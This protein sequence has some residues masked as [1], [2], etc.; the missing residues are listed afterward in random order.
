MAYFIKSDIDTI[1]MGG[2]CMADKIKNN[3]KK[4]FKGGAIAIFV[5]ILSMAL[6]K[7]TDTIAETIV[8]ADQNVG[9]RS[10]DNAFDGEMYNSENPYKILEIVPDASMAELGYQIGGSSLPVSFEDVAKIY[11]DGLENNKG[12]VL[13]KWRSAYANC[14]DKI[15]DILFIDQ[16]GE[17]IPGYD[18]TWK[19]FTVTDYAIKLTDGTIVTGKDRNIFAAGL[20][21][22]DNIMS[23]AMSVRVVECKD[24]TVELL[25]EYN[26][27]LIYIHLK[28]HAGMTFSNLYT[29]MADMAKTYPDKIDSARYP[30]SDSNSKS[31]DISADS[32]LEIYL[33][34]VTTDYSHGLSSLIIDK[35]FLGSNE[36]KNLSKICYLNYSIIPE[37]F[38]QEFASDYNE[39]KWDSNK[40]IILK[41]DKGTISVNGTN[42]EWTLEYNYK[43]STICGGYYDSSGNLNY[44]K[45]TSAYADVSGTITQWSQ[46]MFYSSALNSS[47]KHTHY[48]YWPYSISGSAVNA[49]QVAEYPYIPAG[50]G[51]NTYLR[52][53]VY[54]YIGDNSMDMNLYNGKDNTTDKSY[55]YEG[56]KVYQTEFG[57]LE[58]NSKIDLVHYIMGDVGK[59]K[60][61]GIISVLEVQ[62]SGAYEYNT[63]DGALQILK[64]FNYSNKGITVNNFKKYIEVK[65]VPS[66][67]FNGITDDLAENY[68]LII[69]GTNNEVN[70]IKYLNTK[71]PLYTADGYITVSDPQKPYLNE[72]LAAPGN[73]LTKKAYDRLE[74]YAATGRALILSSDIYNMNTSTV[75]E[76]TYV[77]KLYQLKKYTNVKIEDSKTRLELSNRPVIK[78]DGY[79]ISY[80]DNIMQPNVTIEQLK[81]GKLTITGTIT[82]NTGTT[83]RYKA[84]MYIDSDGDGLFDSEDDKKYDS[85]KVSFS[86]TD[87][88]EFV[89]E[90]PD[91]MSAYTRWKL[92]LT[93]E[94]GF[95]SEE[96]GAFIPEIDVK[97]DEENI[98]IKPVSILQIRPRET[99]NLDMTSSSFKDL[100]NAAS[101]ISGL[102]IKTADSMN[103]DELVAACN[104][105]YKY[106]KENP[107]MKYTMIAFGFINDY[108]SWN[109]Y[110]TWW[111]DIND[112]V[113]LNYIREYIEANKIVLLS[114][115]TVSTLQDRSPRFDYVPRSL[116][117][118]LVPYMGLL[119][120]GEGDFRYSIPCI[121]RINYQAT[122]IAD[123]KYHNE[124]YKDALGRTY[125]DWYY[126]TTTSAKQMNEGQVTDFPYDIPETIEV[127]ATHWQYF[128][129]NL[130]YNE[131]SNDDDVIVWYTLAP[132]GTNDTF[133]YDYMGQ[134]AVNNY[135]IYSKGNVFYTGAGHSGVTVNE[136]KL[137]VN[138]IVKA[139]MTANNV[140]TVSIDNGEY[141]S[142]NFYQIDILNDE[143][144]LPVITFTAKDVDEGYDETAA[145]AET[146]IYYINSSGEKVL[147]KTYTAQKDPVYNRVSVDFNLDEYMDR[148]EVS[149]Q[150]NRFLIEVYDGIDTGFTYF[151]IKEHE[152]F[153]LD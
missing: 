110:D 47:Y 31:K 119:Y 151:N 2:C 130:D 147:L 122:K 69:I 133:L 73:D 81:T 138:T 57:L 13:T 86:E 112:E 74:K 77:Y 36:S 95:T 22:E 104:D 18:Y 93:D 97:N 20:F 48:N 16:N 19:E 42:G 114:H 126:E 92:V 152:L 23:D 54:M 35:S 5:V 24:V 89:L 117:D 101:D 108:G 55:T 125:T 109:Q 85:G 12:E 17:Y 139:L 80:K 52:D 25:N 96:T 128:G 115:D 28:T 40:S 61:D 121:A 51:A 53:R 98:L 94:N 111:D 87:G 134:D 29:Y 60:L 46:N 145:F 141:V 120:T 75:A 106:G 26:P 91:N 41:G 124:A 118:A 10:A 103:K 144:E 65:S 142:E 71:Y 38:I 59:K 49:V 45:N 132:N 113:T 148:E 9:T 21:G 33:R 83:H 62:P 63:Y 131:N 37:T 30:I 1:L 135:Y 27:Q 50:N 149:G 79:G 39:K 6:L 105:A 76:N 8:I 34:S 64:Y 129:L 100:F 127:G 102:Y 116:G 84:A 99:T 72:S 146:K 143:D 14:A 7:T 67:G 32:A 136:E 56:E 90:L 123:S 58:N 140:P 11:N 3:R 82:S 107:L 153:D 43:A 88:F 68:D 137:F 66:N 4:I 70:G 150:N 78:V 15:S 44:C